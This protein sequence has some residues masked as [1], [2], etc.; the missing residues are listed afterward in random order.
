[1][2]CNVRVFFL[3]DCANRGIFPSHCQLPSFIVSELIIENNNNV[4]R[5]SLAI[6]G[7]FIFFLD[8]RLGYVVQTL[9]NCDFKLL[10]YV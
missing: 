7:L 8:G 5:V 4:L 10:S 6:P 2:Q 1:M 3:L 9:S